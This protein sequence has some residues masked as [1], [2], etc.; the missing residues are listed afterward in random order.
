VLVLVLSIAVLEM[1]FMDSTNYRSSR[2][3]IRVRVRKTPH[4]AE[5]DEFSPAEL[6]VYDLN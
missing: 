2:K 6:V 1:A 5:P 3:T 4:A